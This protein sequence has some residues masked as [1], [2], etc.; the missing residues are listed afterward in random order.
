MVSLPSQ[1]PLGREAARKT[2]HIATVV[3][4]IAYA[5]GAPRV[6]LL[7]VLVLGAAIAI[8]IELARVWHPG[9]RAWLDHRVGVL[10][11]AH[12]RVGWAGATWLLVSYAAVVWLAPRQAAIAAM[13][14]VSV[15]DGLAGVVGRA[16]N[17]LRGTRARKTI[18]GSVTCFAASIAGAW[19][20]AHLP[21]A[22]SLVAAAGATVA[23][24]VPSRIDDNVRITAAVVLGILLWHM[25]FS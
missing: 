1:L 2:I 24:W 21:P 13:W 10:F 17:D 25:A 8:L 18:A 16:V 19:A 3:V 6:G 11:R 4:P 7:S 12:E 9:T 23:E 15:G 5:V 22:Q 14:A 20:I